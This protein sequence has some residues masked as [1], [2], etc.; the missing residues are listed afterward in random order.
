M[1]LKPYLQYYSLFGEEMVEIEITMVE[2][3]EY[4]PNYYLVDLT[5]RI[6]LSEPEKEPSD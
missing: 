5:L 2:N 6:L 1:V 3:Q 4:W